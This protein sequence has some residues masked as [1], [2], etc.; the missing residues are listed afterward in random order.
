[1]NKEQKPWYYNEYFDGVN[2]DESKVKPGF[3][4]EEGTELLNKTNEE[5][6]EMVFEK[7]EDDSDDFI[8][9]DKHVEHNYSQ[10]DFE[11]F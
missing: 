2:W 6:L 9:E 11:G 10:E 1:M 7:D 5:L 3:V 8:F 4:L